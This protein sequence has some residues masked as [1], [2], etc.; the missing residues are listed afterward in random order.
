MCFSN[1]YC[2]KIPRKKK[3]QKRVGQRSRHYNNDNIWYY[4]TNS[5][6]QGEI[7]MG[8][9]TS[10]AASLPVRLSLWKVKSSKATLRHLHISLSLDCSL[11]TATTNS[12]SVDIRKAFLGYCLDLAWNKSNAGAEARSRCGRGWSCARH[13]EQQP[14]APGGR[15]GYVGYFSF[16]QNKPHED[17]HDQRR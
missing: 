15:G 9:S 2:T 12:I 17:F 5:V 11:T 3:K 8:N 1:N 16:P 7:N 13:P 10:F 14:W 4:I 6:C